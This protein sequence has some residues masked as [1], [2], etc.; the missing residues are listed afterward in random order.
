MTAHPVVAMDGVI[1]INQAR[2]AAGGV[3][4]GDG[5]GF[6]VTLSQPGSYRLTGPL[7]SPEFVGAIAIT[8]SAVTLDLNGF[9]IRTELPAANVDGINA[10]GQTDLHVRN[11]AV[12]SFGG[13]GIE[14][15]DRARIE[16]VTAGSNTGAGI[17]VGAVSIVIGSTAH[18]NGGDGILGG[19]GCTVSGSTAVF[20][21]G[22]GI[23]VFN[24]STV[25][26][27]GAGSNASRG[28]FVGIGS[29]VSENTVATNGADGITTDAG[30][31][32]L[33]N[34]VTNNGG[35]GIEVGP[36]SSVIGNTVS[37]NARCGLNA[38]SCS[39]CVSGF[40]HN[41]FNANNGSTSNRQ[42]F[43]AGLTRMDSSDASS[44]V[45][46]TNACSSLGLSTNSCA[47]GTAANCP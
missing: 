21:Q 9:R 23:H 19:D 1:E 20:N 13:D 47:V 5:V 31:T 11:G 4:P 24:G 27:N 8:S 14:A 39:Q 38:L 6:P 33:N 29:T 10:T 44:D 17:S 12:E 16:N 40:A 3:T 46:N 28:L 45:L 34:T 15:G 26:R 2:A 22:A 32:V 37:G 42:V 18:G 7:V 35:D 43:G 36:M 25:T 41:V 30:C